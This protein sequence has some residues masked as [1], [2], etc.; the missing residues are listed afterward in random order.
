MPFPIVPVAG[1]LM[2]LLGGLLGGKGQRQPIDPKL[3]EQLFGPQKLAGE[4]QQ[5]Y[6]M[7]ANSP[8]F[9][10]MMQ[11]AAKQGS[12]AS[13]M[14]A[15]NLASRGLSSTPYGSFL[16]SASRGYGTSMQ[17][18][19]KQNLFLQALQTAL[20][21]ISQRQGIYGQSMGIQQQQPTWNQQLGSSLL[22]GGAQGMLGGLGSGESDMDKLMKALG[23]GGGG[24]GFVGSP[25]HPVKYGQ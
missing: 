15:S 13:T 17:L 20:Q 10:A 22:A 3:L 6:A 25:Y 12:R 2:A 7:L 19:G 1:G 8:A 16:K 24:Q 21:N 14:T 11:S 5:L 4:T 18:Q 9:A 23:G